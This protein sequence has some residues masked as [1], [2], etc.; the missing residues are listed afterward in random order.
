MSFCDSHLSVGVLSTVS[1]KYLLAT[2][3]VTN[4]SGGSFDTKSE[5]K[6]NAQYFHVYMLNRLLINTPDVQHIRRILD[7]EISKYP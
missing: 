5:R 7:Q 4:A 6:N 1:L 3:S 2:E